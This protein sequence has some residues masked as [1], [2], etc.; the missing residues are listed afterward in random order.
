MVVS[1]PP[2]ATLTIDGQPTSSV[3]GKRVFTTPEL[4][5][6]KNYH[7]DLEAKVIR[8]GAEQ[9]VRRKVTYQAGDKVE[10]SLDFPAGFLAA[11]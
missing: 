3:S 8:N 6:G 5:P 4:E 7:Y 11:N 9:L 1:L 10:V 2:D